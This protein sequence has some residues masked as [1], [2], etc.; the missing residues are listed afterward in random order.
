MTAPTDATRS[1]TRPLPPLGAALEAEL[2]RL[3]SVAPRRPARQVAI[4]I[5]ASLVYGGGAL[6]LL[7]LRVD[8]DE[9]PMSRLV[10]AGLLWLLGFVV[11]AYLA[12]S[13][14]ASSTTGQRSRSP[15]AHPVEPGSR[16]MTPRWQA[17]TAAA[18]AAPIGLIIAGF[19]VPP[20]DPHS[21]YY[22]PEHLL[23]GHACMWIGLAVA[24][25]PTILGAW[26]LRGALAIRS[27][28]IAAALG[29]A[30][31]SL[32]GLALHLHCGIADRTH[33]GLL[34]GGLVVVAALLSAILAPA[35]SDRPFRSP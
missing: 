20:A 16:S 7:G 10:G 17:A 5:V 34:H 4:W 11:P 1:D 13:P 2:A 6:A 23:R 30:S 14:R 22:G 28:H 25:V 19:T 3:T 29:A 31:G 15:S 33:V 27:R 12:L 18:I 21:I 35:I 32:G 26:L 8:L 9:L 24:L